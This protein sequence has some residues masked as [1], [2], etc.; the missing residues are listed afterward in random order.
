[1]CFYLPV[2]MTTD[3]RTMTI[4]P[5]DIQAE[6]KIEEIGGCLRSSLQ[7]RLWL[8]ALC[9][10]PHRFLCGDIRHHFSVVTFFT[11]SLW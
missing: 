8:N 6:L 5:T 9:K 11:I 7:N 1:M 2:M 10:P 4:S 3:A